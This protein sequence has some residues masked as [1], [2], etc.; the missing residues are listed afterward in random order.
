MAQSEGEKDSDQRIRDLLEH[1]ARRFTY[2]DML[3]EKIVE[4]ALRDLNGEA[5]PVSLNSKKILLIVRN[6]ALEYFGIENDRDAGS[7]AGRA[8]E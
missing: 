1:L 8:P 7:S 5:A 3:R 2:S 4:R 6:V